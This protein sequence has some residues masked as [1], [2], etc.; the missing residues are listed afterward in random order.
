MLDG[1]NHRYQITTRSFWR[2]LLAAH[3]R[4][5]HGD[6]LVYLCWFCPLNLAPDEAHYWDWSRNLA[7][8]YYSKGPLIA[9]LIR[10]STELFGPLSLSLTGSEM[11]AVRLPAVLCGSLLLLG[12]YVLALQTTRSDRLAFLLVLLCA[13]T[14]VASAASI[15]M[16]IDSPFVTCWAWA[17]V[18]GY[19]AVFGNDRW[20]WGLSGV[21]VGLGILAKYTMAAPK[22]ASFWLVSVVHPEFRRY[23][24]Q[25]GFWVM[26]GSR[27]N[28]LPSDYLVERDSWLGNFPPCRAS[29]RTAGQPPITNSAL[30]A[31]SSLWG[32]SPHFLI[33]WGFVAWLGRNDSV[34]VLAERMTPSFMIPVVDVVPDHVRVRRLV[35]SS[36]RTTQLARCRLSFGLH[37]RHALGD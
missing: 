30:S 29:G 12:L 22:L 16:T 27:G 36:K 14:P 2:I 37:S 25:P 23:L 34:S 7:W 6:A 9:W 3:S 8:S 10:L 1:Q 13:I 31:L 32:F 19:R 26:I 11:P 35:N 5:D 20:A 21:L 33:G 24:F 4:P 17:L 28:L 18:V 15:L